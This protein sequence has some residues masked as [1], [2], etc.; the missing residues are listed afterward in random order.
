MLQTAFGDMS[1]LE[2][3][4]HDSMLGEGTAHVGMSA[5]IDLIGRK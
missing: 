4:E 1:D 5:L 3:H 2:I